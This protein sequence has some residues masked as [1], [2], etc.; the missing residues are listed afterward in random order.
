ML[1]LGHVIDTP[2]RIL[3]EYDVFMDENVRLVTLGQIKEHALDPINREKQFIIITPNN[4]RGIET[5][6]ETRIHRIKAPIREASYGLK[7]STISY[8]EGE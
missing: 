1:A 8:A 6:K 7:Q 4:L 2:F 5:N 3:D